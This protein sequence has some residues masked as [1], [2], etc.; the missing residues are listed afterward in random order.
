ME[1]GKNNI[2]ITTLTDTNYSH[3]KYLGRDKLNDS[4]GSEFLDQEEKSLFQK[5]KEKPNF[6][7]SLTHS[8]HMLGNKNLSHVGNLSKLN[9]N[10]AMIKE[11]SLDITRNGI[12]D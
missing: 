8:A 6:I 10:F 3:T 11:K 4:A 7:K 2:T 9:E 5:I 1:G 12:C